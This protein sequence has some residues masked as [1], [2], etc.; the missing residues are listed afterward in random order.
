MAEAEVK[1]KPV[2][3]SARK[4][5]DKAIAGKPF[6]AYFVHH[7]KRSP[8]D[9]AIA[10]RETL[11]GKMKMTAT[12]DK[13][14]A[15]RKAVGDAGWLAGI[16]LKGVD[17]FPKG[18]EVGAPRWQKFYEDFKPTLEKNLAEVY[19][20]PRVTIDD[21]VARAERMIRLNAEY[22]YVPKP[23]GPADIRSGIEEIKKIKLPL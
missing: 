5:L 9:A 6:Y 2:D 4:Y 8:T 20:L 18:I 1:V 13:W 23:L 12:W 19:K 7:P 10:M 17:R 3:V 15:K 16:E 11:E 22:K 14:E 21:A